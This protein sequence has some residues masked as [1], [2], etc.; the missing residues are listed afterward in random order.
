MVYTLR[1]TAHL[2]PKKVILTANTNKTQL[3]D[4][5]VKADFQ[6][7]KLVLVVTGSDSVPVEITS[8]CIYMRQDMATL[9]EEGGILIVQ[10]V[11]CV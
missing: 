10:Q 8:G 5:I 4:L 11:S 7:H 1:C 2:P 9:Q 3:I 6:K